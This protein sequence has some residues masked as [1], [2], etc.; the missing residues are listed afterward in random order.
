[1]SN[2]WYCKKCCRTIIHG[3]VLNEERLEYVGKCL[4]TEARIVGPTII[5]GV[6]PKKEFETKGWVNI[7]KDIC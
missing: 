7:C 3:Y 4:C 1:M 5:N 2:K 6:D